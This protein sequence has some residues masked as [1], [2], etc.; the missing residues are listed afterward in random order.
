MADV[1]ASPEVPPGAEDNA[2]PKADSVAVEAEV[3]LSMFD[4]SKKK[5]KKKKK[6]KTEGDDE[7]GGGDGED[8]EEGEGRYNYETL[9]ERIQNLLHVNNPEL[10][11]RSRITLKPPQLM[12]MGTRKTLWAN[13]QDICQLMKRQPEHVFS[14]VVAELGT[15]GSIDGNQRLVLRGKYVPK[16]IES[17]LR[18][19]IVEY[20]TCQMC[21]SPNTTLT[22]DPVSRL[23]FVHCQ[24]CGSSRSVAPIR[25]GFHAQTRADRRALRN[26]VK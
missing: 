24:D 14:F 22:R 13:F 20:V 16:Y 25:S 7:A 5:K 18:K 3:D 1:D 9:L 11:E 23:F 10:A 15:E 19:Y 6:I 2:A 8:R 26:A 4:L 12:R 17:L 21:R